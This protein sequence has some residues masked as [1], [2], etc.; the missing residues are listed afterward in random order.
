MRF[1]G[2]MGILYLNPSIEKSLVKSRYKRPVKPVWFTGRS[3]Q[4]GLSRRVLQT[5]RSA[6]TQ[7][8]QNTGLLCK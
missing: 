6:I 1:V 4:H 7:P 2:N 5:I 3:V 8:H